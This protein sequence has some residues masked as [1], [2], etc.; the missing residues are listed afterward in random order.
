MIVATVEAPGFS[1]VTTLRFKS[2][3][4]APA[5]QG[6]SFEGARLQPCRY[7]CGGVG[8]QPL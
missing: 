4:S 6:A 2:G 8:L 7:V 5:L 1:L 3:A